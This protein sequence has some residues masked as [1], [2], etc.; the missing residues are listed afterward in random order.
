M[1]PVLNPAGQCSVDCMLGIV[2]AP[3]IIRPE[4]FL[5]LENMSLVLFLVTK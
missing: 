3:T 4:E 2:T 1:S 5:I